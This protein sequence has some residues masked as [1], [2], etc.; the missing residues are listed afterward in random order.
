MC[1]VTSM[2]YIDVSD[3]MAE[4]GATQDTS[5]TQELTNHG[6]LVA[7]INY[8]SLAQKKQFCFSRFQICESGVSQMFNSA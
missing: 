2:E 5:D 7:P 8:K 1:V 4:P 3:G 6:W